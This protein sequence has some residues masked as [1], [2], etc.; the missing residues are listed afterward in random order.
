MVLV[1]KNLPAN[2]GDSRDTVPSLGQ[3]MSW[4]RKRQPTPVPLPENF[5]GQRGLVGSCP[6]GRR[7]GHDWPTEH[8]CTP[9]IHKELVQVNL[10]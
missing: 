9:K 2:A 1:V 7:V 6:S 10:K 5:D 4:R 3:E 8:T